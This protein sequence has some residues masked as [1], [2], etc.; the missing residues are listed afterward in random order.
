MFICSSSGRPFRTLSHIGFFARPRDPTIENTVL[1]FKLLCDVWIA[2]MP[3][4]LLKLPQF[5]LLRV[6][7]AV[8]WILEEKSPSWTDLASDV[9]GSRETC[10]VCAGLL[11]WKPG[12]CAVAWPKCQFIEGWFCFVLYS[13]VDLKIG[14]TWTKTKCGINGWT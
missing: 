9:P 6:P 13:P 11:T 12:L 10:S 8:A 1:A 5:Q 2:Q 4:C 7:L 14:F 3:K